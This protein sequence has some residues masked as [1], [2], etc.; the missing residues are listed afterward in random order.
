MK[1]DKFRE[2][3]TLSVIIVM[4]AICFWLIL[5]NYRKRCEQTSFEIQDEATKQMAHSLAGIGE[6][7]SEKEI[8]VAKVKELFEI[9]SGRYTMLTQG[10]QVLYIKDDLTTRRYLKSTSQCVNQLEK[11]NVILTSQEFVFGDESYKI[12]VI[13]SGDYGLNQLRLDDFFLYLSLLI[14]I[15]GIGFVCYV[16]SITARQH[17]M[18]QQLMAESEKVREHLIKEETLQESLIKEKHKSSDVKE[19][20]DE[21]TAQ[22]LLK[23]STDPELYP[24]HLLVVKIK[25]GDRYYTRDEMDEVKNAIKNRLTSNQI[26]CE[27]GKGEFA[28]LLYKTKFLMA[29]EL[30]S[31]LQMIWEQDPAFQRYEIHMLKE[32]VRER[33]KADELLKWMREKVI[34]MMEE[35][36]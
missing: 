28:V 24:L 33:E 35:E 29:K 21:K 3:G 13:S 34:E 31:K 4:F 16:I 20:Y 11:Q 17:R 30:Y 12:W 8:L 26:L 6:Y 23:K 15:T 2:I 10:E 27:I 36:R 25:M 19:N 1:K 9:S 5:S 22:C 32:E 18:N 7:E 14:I